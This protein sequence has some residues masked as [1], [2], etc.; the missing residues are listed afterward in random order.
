MD[1]LT[2]TKD[3]LLEKAANHPAIAYAMVDGLADAPQ[4]SLQIDRAKAEALGLSL[5]LLRML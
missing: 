1:V 2:K 5:I 4:L 3:S